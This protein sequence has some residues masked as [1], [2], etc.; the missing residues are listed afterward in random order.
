ME[1]FWKKNAHNKATC[2]E[3]K[4]YDQHEYAKDFQPVLFSVGPVGHD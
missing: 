1:L 2:S 4:L 3:S